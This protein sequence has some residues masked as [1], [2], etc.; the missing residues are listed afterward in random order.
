M[1]GEK[2]EDP[3]Q[4]TEP[5]RIKC[6]RIGLKRNKQQ[7]FSTK[8]WDVRCVRQK[9]GEIREIRSMF[10]LVDKAREKMGGRTKNKSISKVPINLNPSKT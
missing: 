6:T 1:K 10:L 4:N 2:I 8:K 7:E 5:Q 9:L 3:I